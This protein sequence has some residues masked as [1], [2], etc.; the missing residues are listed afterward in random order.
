MSFHFDIEKLAQCTGYLLA[1][2][3]DRTHNYFCVM[4]LLYL[5][6]RMGLQE[7]GAPVVGDE[8]YAMDNGPVLSNLLDLIKGRAN[9]VNQS[10]WASHFST[11]NYELASLSPT[12]DDLISVYERSVIDRIFAAHGAKDWRDLRSETHDLPEW[13]ECQP[14][15]GSSNRIDLKTML[16]AVGREADFER[17]GQEA[18]EDAYFAQLFGG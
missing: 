17:I 15:D 3:P 16:K 4:K 11:R 10:Y 5:A 9:E 8:P 12:E 14:P 7:R 2:Y 18:R 6:E 13:R 1:K